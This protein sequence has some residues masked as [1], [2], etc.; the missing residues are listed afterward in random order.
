MEYRREYINQIYICYPSQLRQR[1]TYAIL[2]VYTNTILC[3]MERYRPQKN[4]SHTYLPS[5]ISSA[6]RLYMF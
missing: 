6:Q 3:T 5:R 4:K 1:H 2:R